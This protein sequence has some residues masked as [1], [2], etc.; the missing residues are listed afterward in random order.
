MLDLESIF[1]EATIEQPEAVSMVPGV[2]VASR[3][4]G[5][6]RRPDVS[7]LMGWEAPNLPDW[8]RW[9]ARSTFDDLP[10]PPKGF[11]FGQTQEPTPQLAPCCVAGGADVQTHLPGM[12]PLQGQ[13]EASDG[14]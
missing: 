9:W 10:E 8:Q 1:G 12:E 3:F 6:V 4:A 2:L 14:L 13:S 5:W 7:G 11:R